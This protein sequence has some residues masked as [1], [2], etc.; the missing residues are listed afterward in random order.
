MLQAEGPLGWALGRYPSKIHSWVSKGDSSGQG[1]KLTKREL[2]LRTHQT[3]G[4]ILVLQGNFQSWLKLGQ[5][6]IY[7]LLSAKSWKNMQTWVRVVSSEGQNLELLSVDKHSKS[8]TLYNQGN[9]IEKKGQ[10]RVFY[11]I[12]ILI[13]LMLKRRGFCCNLNHWENILWNI[14]GDDFYWHIVRNMG[15]IP[16]LLVP[17]TCFK[18]ELFE[19]FILNHTK[20]IVITLPKS[21]YSALLILCWQRTWSINYCCLWNIYFHSSNIF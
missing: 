19:S 4:K 11:F 8:F 17:F 14:L 20:S 13:V 1:D 3:H 21:A 7:I 12:P 10:G 18:K 5:G 9:G 15:T 16:N 2:Q 6:G